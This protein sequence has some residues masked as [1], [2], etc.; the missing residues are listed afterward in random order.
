MITTFYGGGKGR[1]STI[2]HKVNENTPYLNTD[3]QNTLPSGKT[4]VGT[5]KGDK[6]APKS[7][8]MDTGSEDVSNYEKESVAEIMRAQGVKAVNV[9]K[10]FLTATA[11]DF[12][13]PTNVTKYPI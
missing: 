4:S 9:A 10:I 8:V 3:N 13:V 5:P 12:V 2:S 1:E 11:I 7:I 6:T